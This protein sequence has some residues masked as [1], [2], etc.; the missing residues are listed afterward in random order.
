L[1]SESQRNQ[2]NRVKLRA[3][4]ETLKCNRCSENRAAALQF[5]HKDPSIKQLDISRAVWKRS[6]KWILREIDKCEVLC[7]NCHAVETEK[8][9]NIKNN[10]KFSENAYAYIKASRIGFASAGQAGVSY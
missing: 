5:H 10:N 7:A 6:W 1:Y 4:K 8:Q 2:E 9:H 3:L